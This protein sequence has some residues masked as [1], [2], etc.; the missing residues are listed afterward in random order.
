MR[1][2]DLPNFSSSDL[3]EA[4]AFA[5]KVVTKHIDI[6]DDPTEDIL[7]HLRDACDFID[8]GLLSRSKDEDGDGSKQVGVV[9]HCTQ[10]ISRSASFV[11]AYCTYVPRKFCRGSI[12]SLL[13]KFVPA[14]TVAFIHFP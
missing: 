12:H 10:G 6:D 3:F 4:D 1:P 8:G 11:I 7:C 2:D 5:R 13:I 14:L 9:V